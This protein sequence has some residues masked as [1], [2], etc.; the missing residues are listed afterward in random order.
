MKT[1]KEI[2]EALVSGNLS[3]EE[4]EKILVSSKLTHLEDFAVLDQGRQERSGIPEVIFAESKDGR[5]VSQIANSMVETNGFALIS[6]ADEEK[7]RIV[8]SNKGDYVADVSGHGGVHTILLHDKKWKP[9]EPEG[10]IA[11]ITAGTSDVPYAKEVEAI[12]KVMGVGVLNFHDIGVAGIHRLVEP[13]KEIIS[14]DVDAIV[15][16]AGMEGALP[17]V[18]ASLV[19]IPVIGLPV[20]VGYG[21]GGKGKTAL[22]S[23]LQSC[24]PGLA[25]V[26]IGNGIGAGSMA[27][28]I[29]KRAHQCRCR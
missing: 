1:T 8:E 23:M 5:T 3:L 17:T 11:V 15:V 13:I 19:N 27:S 14:S 28:L 6:R 12:A 21:F 2:L 10:N 24:A 26:N 9:P 7:V 29:A 16:L 25:V 22:A 20:P 4:S 18:I